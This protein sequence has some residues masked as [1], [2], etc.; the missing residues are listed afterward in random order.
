M[1][2]GF[3]PKAFQHHQI[4]THKREGGEVGEI[5]FENDLADRCATD[6]CALSACLGD[7]IA[8]QLAAGYKE[9]GMDFDAAAL[10]FFRFAEMWFVYSVA[11][12]LTRYKVLVNGNPA[13]NLIRALPSVAAL[14]GIVVVMATGSSF[15]E[16]LIG[17]LSDLTLHERVWNESLIAGVPA[18]DRNVQGIEIASQSAR[19][20]TT[21]GGNIRYQPMRASAA[22]IARHS[23]FPLLSVQKNS[24][25]AC[26][27]AHFLR[28]EGT[29]EA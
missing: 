25:S 29:G 7:A 23:T 22:A 4:Q 11:V 26:M 2:R 15:G 5:H 3:H 8:R 14:A 24:K 12:E 1:W 16:K 19:R 20:R 10:A 9:I 27:F 13:K 28:T 17:Q 21:R 18:L 6:K